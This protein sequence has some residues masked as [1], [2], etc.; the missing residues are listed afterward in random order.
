MNWVVKI[1]MVIFA[2]YVV[3]ALTLYFLQ[4][5]IM[6]APDTNRVL[7]SAV[8]LPGLEEVV[9]QTKQGHKLYS[10]YLPAK[11]GQPTLLFFH[12]NGGNVANREEKFR[13]LGARGFGVLM[14]GYRGFGGSEGS[15][16][17]AAMV[18]DAQLAYEH[19]KGQGLTSKQIVIYGESIGSSVAVQL[20]A[21]VQSAAVILEAPMYSV[22]SI[23]QSR[24]P[25]VPVRAFLRDKFETNLFI[26]QIKSP[27]LIVHGSD[28]GVIPLSSGLALYDV[29]I[30]PKR[31]HVVDGAQHNNLYDFPI[32]QE[33]VRFLADYEISK[34][35][36]MKN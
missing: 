23:A 25:Y 32:V 10:W 20:A 22:L 7:P 4:G 11:N 30:E 1:L 21:K 18:E 15:P 8:N 12:G 29:A 16:S 34:I 6:F 28:D 26:K 13:Q 14:L 3:G 17:E 35:E 2:L 33:I 36:L 5:R 31:F 19:L 27:L 24:Y 9:L